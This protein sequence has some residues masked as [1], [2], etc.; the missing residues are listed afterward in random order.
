MLGTIIA[1][2]KLFRRTGMDKGI[3][4]A[5]TGSVLRMAEVDNVAA[6]VANINTSG[7]KRT[8][9][10]ARLYPLTEGLSKTQAAVYPGARSMT[11]FDKFSMDQSQ[12]T[13]LTTGNPLDLGIQGDGFFVV[14][15]KGQRGYTR[16]GSL[17]INK[18]GNL[19]TGSGYSVLGTDDK[20]IKIS[21]EGTT[22]PVI[23]T[24]G[25]ITLDGNAVGT[26]KLVNVADIRSISDSLYSGRETGA[27]K[28]DIAQ[29]RIERSNVNPV[30]ELVAMIKAQREF[31]SLQQVIRTF[32]QLSQRTVSEIA[33]V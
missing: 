11:V 1:L 26:I 7:Y 27:S 29:G 33:K 23:G 3:Y 10:S 9:F 6:N 25:S 2:L 8:S 32:D 14:D 18:E 22:A 28:G 24:D 31:Q 19:V 17:S 4:V 21:K 15:I 5:M 12:G 30:R 20:P 16:N 13:L